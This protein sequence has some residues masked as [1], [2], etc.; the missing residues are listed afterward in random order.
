[1]M[2]HMSNFLFKN[3]EMVLFIGDSIT[4]C[5]RRAQAAPLGEGYVKLSI[6]LITARYPERKIHFINKRPR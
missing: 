5:G 4:D 6:D 1:M 2:I 3:G